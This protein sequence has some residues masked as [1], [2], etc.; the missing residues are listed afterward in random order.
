MHLIP[1]CLCVEYEGVSYE[2]QNYLINIFIK[3]EENLRTYKFYYSFSALSTYFTLLINKLPYVEV[4]AEKSDLPPSFS[5]L[6]NLG[7]TC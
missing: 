4:N 3:E 5:G 6:T 1:I 2:P 7:A